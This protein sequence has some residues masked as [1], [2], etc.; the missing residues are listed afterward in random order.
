MVDAGEF[1]IFILD[2][3]DQDLNGDRHLISHNN[4]TISSKML[5]VRIKEITR[6]REMLVC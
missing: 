1:F 2:P 4:T 5:V 3:L 6:K